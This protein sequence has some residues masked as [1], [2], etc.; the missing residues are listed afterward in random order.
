MFKKLAFLIVL[1]SMILT[2]CQPAVVATEAPVVDAP[3][4]TEAP[5]E[6]PVA[7][8]AP[9]KVWTYADMTVGFLQTG[10]EGGWRAANTASFKE[11]A[12]QLGLN[13]KF[14]D[15]QND[16][17]KQVAGFQQFIEDPEVDVIIMSPLE[18]TGW[19]Q[20]LKDAAAAGKPVIL[21][22]RR[23][24][25]FEDLYVTFIG[26]DFVEEG[27]KAGTEMCK[28]LEGSEKKNVWE[29]VGNVGAAPAIDR[30]KGFRETAEAC[31]ITV[32]NSQTANW[33]VVEGKQ[34]TEA[35]LKESKDVQGIFGQ[36]DEM[37]FGAIEALKEAG[38][39]P[40]V[41]V[42]IISV[43]ATAGAF[44][45]ML[46]GTLNVTVE[47]NPLLAPQVYE[48]ALA[49]LNG[50][51]LPKWIPSQESVFYMVDPNLKDI[52]AGRKY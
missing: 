1:A 4:A 48:A 31:G 37:A 49:A 41:D 29:L 35:W 43:D 11:T 23:I 18:V 17:A 9:A 42:K 50:E 47:C 6:A 3:A 10:S 34:V 13:L 22:D 14:Y 5:V 21:S 16:L 8:E 2:A 19:E 12:E 20:V 7:T 45:A 52:A 51:T 26:A 39:V 15:S 25:G 27:R 32:V 28:L 40:A 24:D 44:Q 33:S 46:D 30:G 36:N 38:L